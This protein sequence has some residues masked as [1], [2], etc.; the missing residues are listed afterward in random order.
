MLKKHLHDFTQ[1]IV[2]KRHPKYNKHKVAYNASREYTL[3]LFHNSWSL[4]TVLWYKTD[5]THMT[6]LYISLFLVTTER[7]LSS[8]TPYQS[9][10]IFPRCCWLDK[11]M[12]AERDTARNVQPWQPHDKKEVIVLIP[13]LLYFNLNN[14][15][16]TSKHW[17][18][19][20]FV[21]KTVPLF[22]KLHGMPPKTQTHKSVFFL[23]TME[24]FACC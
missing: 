2:L 23:K 21:K 10:S 24:C 20:S 9:W 5:I 7:N 13:P 15:S 3:L 19:I 17:R 12:I 1:T 18:T 14:S 4:E 11:P 22:S 6:E 8:K 16:S